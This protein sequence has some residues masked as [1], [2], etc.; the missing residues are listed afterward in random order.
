MFITTEDL[1]QAIRLHELDE[2]TGGDDTLVQAAISTAVAEMKPYLFRYDAEKIFS[3]TGDGR[4]PLL[5]R[6]AVDI[7]IFEVVSISRPDQDLENRRALY[8]RAIDWLRQVKD[9]DMPTGLPRLANPVA[10]GD[11][12]VSG[13][14]RSPRN[15][16]F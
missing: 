12:P 15:N 1:K 9:D 13:G 6:F 3:A 4:E 16:Y 7:T 14:G 5:V 11:D 2:I 8:K 10:S